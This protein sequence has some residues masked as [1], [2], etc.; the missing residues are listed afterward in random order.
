M[1]ENVINVINSVSN[2]KDLTSNTLSVNSFDKIASSNKSEVVKLDGFEQILANI[3]Q[4]LNSN[5]SQAETLSLQQLSGEQANVRDVV[6]SIMS[7]ERS[8]NTAVAIRDKI[9]QAYMEISRMQI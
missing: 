5:I 1:L 7:A 6:N 2:S 8:L 4:N 9:I 3:S